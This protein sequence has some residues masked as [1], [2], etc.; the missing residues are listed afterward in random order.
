MA[1]FDDLNIWNSGSLNFN[2]WAWDFLGGFFLNNY[3]WT[4]VDNL[5]VD[6]L[7]SANVDHLKWDWFYILEG[8][9]LNVSCGS[10][11]KRPW[12]MRERRATQKW[13]IFWWAK[14]LGFEGGAEGLQR[15]NGIVGGHVSG[16]NMVELLALVGIKTWNGAGIVWVH[17]RDV[18]TSDFRQT[19]HW[20]PLPH[21][22]K[23]LANNWA[24]TN[25]ES[26]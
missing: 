6:N 10:Q 20:H 11:A 26:D 21:H 19:N 16:W 25:H 15:H 1:F 5:G 12:T 14:P 8:V 3:P 4:N 18:Y 23:P 13:W 9:S 17:T 24:P 2:A 7:G 22:Q